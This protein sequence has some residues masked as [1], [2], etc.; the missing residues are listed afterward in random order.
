MNGF[1][2]IRARALRLRGMTLLEVL[3][4]IG[5]LALMSVLLYGAFTS[6]SRGKKGEEKRIERSKQ[7]REAVARIVRELSSSFL[8][9]HTPQSPA[10]ITRTTVFAGKSSVNF[11]RVDFAAFAHR[12]VDNDSK[13]SDQA[14]VSYFVARDPENEDKMDLVRR[15]QSPMDLDPYKGG[16]VNVLAEDVEEFDLR[17]LDPMTGQWVETWDSSSTTG[18]LARL[19]VEVKITLKMKGI[20]N[21]PPFLFVTKTMIPIQQPL[22]FGIPR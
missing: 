6:M 13:E 20:D 12:R 8:S 16:I 11:D 3:V 14:E 9:M 1:R 2:S 19:P 22:N 21:T 17:Y 7:G 5:I 10:L 4:A 15:E 18:Q